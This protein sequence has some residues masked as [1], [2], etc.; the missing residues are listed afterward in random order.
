MV[1]KMRGNV[2]VTGASRGIGKAIAG[3][4]A[5]EHYSVYMTCKN[6]IEILEQQAREWSACYEVPC[7]AYQC[8]M[9]DVQQVSALMKKLPDIDIVIN[10]AGIS[11]IG[12]LTDMTNEEWMT[13]L[14]TNLSALFWVCR[15][16]AKGM[17]KKH[18]GKIINISS[19]SG[20]MGLPGQA[21]YSSS[22]AGV[23]ALTKVAAKEFAAKNVCCNAIAPGFI[24]TDM[25]KDL[26]NT[27]DFINQI[28]QKR[29]GKPEDVANLAAFLA[30]EESDYITGEV[31]RIDG[32]LAM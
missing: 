21:N 4:F 19:V 25:T 31:I 3:R 7:I 10:N 11:Y 13:I 15:D 22:K 12:L 32:G 30:S 27:E 1:I 29:L 8:D 24:T 9:G 26:G 5:K 28:P 16:A 20:L 6:H 14:N 2:L 17:I 23:I 18:Q